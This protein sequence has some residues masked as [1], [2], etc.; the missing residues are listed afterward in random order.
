MGLKIGF[1]AQNRFCSDLKGF[2]DSVVA[3]QHMFDRISG[4][5]LSIWAPD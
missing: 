1:A 4:K 2:F 5:L 3:M